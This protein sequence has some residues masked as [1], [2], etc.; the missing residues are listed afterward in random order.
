VEKPGNADAGN[1]GMGRTGGAEFFFISGQ[2]FLDN[3]I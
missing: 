3:K 1:G 2:I